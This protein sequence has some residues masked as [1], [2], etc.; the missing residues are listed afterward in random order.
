MGPEGLTEIEAELRELSDELTAPRA[1]E[2]LMCYLYRMMEF[3]CRGHGFTRR[4]QEAAAPRATALLR[5]LARM[6]ACCCECEVFWNAYHLDAD[7]FEFDAAGEPVMEPM[8][9]CHGVR[10]GSTQPCPLWQPNP[11]WSVRRRR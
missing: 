10:K 1:G 2:C 5:R 9:A 3:G 11:L 6:G 7:Y 4:Y 8:P